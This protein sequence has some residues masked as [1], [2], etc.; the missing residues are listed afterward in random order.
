LAL[1]KEAQRGT[2][3]WASQAQ[4]QPTMVFLRHPLTLPYLN[5]KQ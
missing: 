2:V 1:R 3:C 5:K 4:H